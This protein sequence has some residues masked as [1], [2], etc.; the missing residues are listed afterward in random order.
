MG[1]PRNSQRIRRD[2]SR[3]F[4]MVDIPTL[5]GYT[6][7]L[8]TCMAML[9]LLLR[10]GRGCGRWFAAPFFAGG[11]G[12]LCLVQPHALPG[13]WG[14]HLGAFFISLAYA[15]GWQA[16]RALFDAG[17]R[18]AWLVGPSVL[19]FLLTWLAFDPLKWQ[20]A[21]AAM[22]VGLVGGYSLGAAFELRQR[23]ETAPPSAR[24]L[25]AVF[26]TAAFLAF[27]ALPFVAV[28]PEP[29]GAAAPKSWAVIFYNVQILV[30]V[31]LAASL[32]VLVHKERAAQTFYDQSI[33]DPLTRLYNR[34]FLNERLAQWESRA[35]RQRAVL[36]FDIDHFK[37]VNDLH[38][39]AAGDSV[40]T[41]V[42]QLATRTFRKKDWLFRYGGEEFLCVL[43]DTTLAEAANIA[44]RLCAAVAE[45]RIRTEGMIISV[46][47]SVG[48]AGATDGTTDVASLVAEADRML[49]R[50]KRNGRNR[51]E[52]AGRTAR[53][54]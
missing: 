4:F 36:F 5:L 27:G 11:L 2:A 34:R 17:P 19:W 26:G 8:L 10:P 43:P 22:R 23:R 40:I 21:N 48:V 15:F 7:I 16:I 35:D 50:A 24:T 53:T 13:R 41:A 46:S 28:L 29:L 14:L 20:V 9:A 18:W 25:L 37:R 52:V 54:A 31:L 6:S 1:L 51:I 33:R 47:I 3:L 12:C 39:H 42:A 32:M 30:E 49:Y 38:G 44:E 45:E